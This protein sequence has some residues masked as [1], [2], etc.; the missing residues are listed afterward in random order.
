M[1]ASCW[2]DLHYNS[3]PCC[4]EEELSWWGRGQKCKQR[5]QSGG[6]LKWEWRWSGLEW[7]W[8][9]VRDESKSCL[10]WWWWRWSDLARIFQV[11]STEFAGRLG[12]E[13]LGKW[14]IKTD[15]MVLFSEAGWG[16]GEAE[17]HWGTRN[18][19]FCFANVKN[20][21]FEMFLIHLGEEHQIGSSVC[22]YGLWEVGDAVVNLVL[23][24]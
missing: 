22:K 20:V 13:S 23:M 9:Q 7:W 6:V 24:E 4:V 2:S 19:E 21:T 1:Y 15:P 5:D 12:S 14:R 10:E 8:Y 11:H 3:L 17:S 18:E 16:C